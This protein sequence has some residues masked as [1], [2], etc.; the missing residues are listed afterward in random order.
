MSIAI[1]TDSTADI[2]PEYL[3]EYNIH[4]M[5]NI[6][7]IEG[8]EVEDGESFSRQA[9]YEKLPFMKSFPTTSTASSGSYQKLYES[10]LQK[11]YNQIISLH[12]S[13]LLSGIFNAARTGAQAFEKY[14]HVIDSHQVSLGLGFQ[15]LAAAQAVQRGWP[16]ESILNHIEN[17]RRR[18]RLI[19]MF[20][21]LEYV[22]RSGRVSWAK[23]GL[24]T[25][26]RI[27]PFVEVKEGI[28]RSLGE[29]RTRRKGIERLVTMI[30]NLG[31]LEYLAVL[32][33]NAEVD[34]SQV[35]EA[36]K[37][38][39]T[40]MSPMIVNVTTIIGAHVGPNGLG[41]AAVTQW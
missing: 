38:K 11:G 16:V 40:G 9:F 25:I 31:N 18:V 23:A 28:V 6:I 19:A 37:A 39:V 20:D 2:P 7:V 13:S 33:T 3:A 41:V 4:V 29:V 22:R 30:R 26:L 21:T 12:A 24:G 34:A 1:V 35:L 36:L 10:L 14:V 15:V 8:Q 17:V 27:K 32:H 5:P